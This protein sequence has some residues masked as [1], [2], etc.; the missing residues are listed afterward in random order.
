MRNFCIIQGLRRSNYTCK[1]NEFKKVALILNGGRAVT[2]NEDVRRTC[3][4]RF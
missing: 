2:S 4:R 3:V 1:T